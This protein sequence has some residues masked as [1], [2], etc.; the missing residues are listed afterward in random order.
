M[1]PYPT[2]VGLGSKGHLRH[3]VHVL[4][5]DEDPQ[6]LAAVRRYVMPGRRYGKLHG[7]NL[8]HL[9]TDQRSAFGS[10]LSKAAAQITDLELILLLKSEW[11]ARLTAGWLIAISRRSSFR[12]LISELLLEDAG[13]EA[14]KG[15]S[16]ALTCFGAEL[17]AKILYRYLEGAL[18]PGRERGGQAWAL[19]GLMRLDASLGTSYA[20]SLLGVGGPW[21]RWSGSPDPPSEQQLIDF[22]SAFA[23]IHSAGRPIGQDAQRDDVRAQFREWQPSTPSGWFTLRDESVRRRLDYEVSAATSR[24]GASANL[25]P[26]AIAKCCECDL[27]LFNTTPGYGDWLIVDMGDRAVLRQDDVRIFQSYLLAGEFMTQHS[28]GR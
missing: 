5:P 3:H 14:S 25:E 7:W 11:R 22:L 6:I 28:H 18:A 17:D 23:E 1:N 16:F 8:K 21:A 2:C 26:L 27:I 19:G 24:R 13:G 4:M 10:E 9:E 20:N 12:K 15:I